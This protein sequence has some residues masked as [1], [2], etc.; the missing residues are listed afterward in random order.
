MKCLS[1]S[2][3]MRVR[4]ENFKYDACGLPYVTLV[5]VQVHRCSK[6]GEFEVAVPRSE[7]LH[8]VIAVSVARKR[9]RLEAAEVRFLRKWLGWSGADF[10]ERMGVSAETVSRWETG[11]QQMGATA[12]RL[13]RL[14]VASRTPQR[15]Y[16]LDLLKEIDVAE[17]KPFRLGLEARGGGWRA[18]A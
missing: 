17:R 1:C 15:D 3:Q 11:A 5:G 18:V 4:R 12:D 2:A 16:S 7:D 9:G 14:M 6:C 10:A 13:L 8:R